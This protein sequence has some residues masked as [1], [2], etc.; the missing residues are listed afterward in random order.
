MRA[1]I[2]GAGH[3]GVTAAF[4][5]RSE[6]WNDEV[7]ILSGE[8]EVPYHKPP[9]S[10]SFLVDDTALPTPLKSEKAYQDAQIACR[11]GVRCIAIDTER[12]AVDLSDGQRLSYDALVLATG[13]T[14]R[15][16][17]GAVPQ[18]VYT[19]RDVSDAACL[20]SALMRAS[21]LA[22]VGGG[23]IGLEVSAS[24][25]G[26]GIAVTVI[27]REAR[28]LARVASEPTS[29]AMKALHEGHGVEVRTQSAVRS[30]AADQ[31]GYV[32]A[33]VLEDGTRLA[34]DLVLIAIGAVPVVDLAREANLDVDDGIV[35]DAHG[36]TSADGV[37]AAGDCT[38]FAYQGGN[39]RLESVQ[40][41][42]DQA[43]VA[44]ADIAGRPS[45]Y[46]PVPWFWS[47]QYEI[48]MQIAGLIDTPDRIV[49]RPGASERA[50]SHWCYRD[51]N[52]QGV[53]SIGC[54]RSHMLA[55]RCLASGIAPPPDKIGEP[56]F[57]PLKG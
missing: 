20:R 51:G 25:R 41:A 55:R 31:D 21:H 40:N 23:Y 24:A 26:L 1:V 27:E 43:R 52:L 46:S 30:F 33:L 54:A 7:V 16:W 35:V 32:S 38:R 44:A 22:V 49:K 19:L 47:D 29:L 39:L 28:L 34:T 42:T 18:G 15:L 9:L 10:K 12:R 53:E 13:A 6:G 36:R 37:W 45:N 8:N 48:K 17:P 3:A 57:D 2:V 5:L 4:A 14:A 56:C 11:P 50:F